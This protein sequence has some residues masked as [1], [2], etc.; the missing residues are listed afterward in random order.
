MEITCGELSEKYIEKEV[1]LNGWCRYIRD[2][3]GKLFIDLADRYGMTQLVFEGTVKEQA[4]KLGKEYVIHAIGVV[5]KREEDT[6][7]RTNPTGSVEV[8]VEKFDIINNSKLPPFE[9]IDEKQSFLPSEELRMKYRYLDLR[10]KEMIKRV[11]FRDK[12]AKVT[13]KYLWDNGFL[14]LETPTLV[15]DTYETGSRTFLVPS[16]F[17]PGK[18]YSLPQSP[19]IYKQL[20]MVAGLDK[21]FQMAKCYRDEDPREDRQPEFTQVDIEVSFKNEKYIQGLIEEL[22]MKVFESLGKKLKIPFRHMAYS[23]AIENY[24]SDK[25]DL[26]FDSRIVDITEIMKL[27]D[28]NI[29]KRVIGGGGRVKAMK[30]EADFDGK[31]GILDKNYMLKVIDTAKSL[32]LGGLTWLYVKDSTIKSEPESIA[33]SIGK[34]PCEKM[35]DAIKAEDGDIIVMCS[36]ASE[37]LLLEV[38]G[39]LRKIIGDKVAKYSSEYEFLWVDEFP[40]FEKDEITGKLKPSHNPF[41]APTPETAHLIETEPEKVLSRQYDIVLN[42]VEIGG[43]SIRINEAELQKRALHAIGMSDKSINDSFGFLIEALEYGAP[44]EGG[45]ALGFDRLIALLYGETDI[46]E[47]ILFPKNKKYESLLDGSPT[48]INPKRLRED[49][50]INFES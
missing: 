39:K 46:R 32:G 40:L 16:R 41:T 21:Y 7:D 18:F 47:F 2:H 43:G 22:M 20:C 19:Q 45:I 42:G 31:K 38:M 15:K 9:L 4:D 27:S 3:G 49:F 28:Y 11:E 33:D 30:F 13:R 48:I 10:R 26:R 17:N 23:Y 1:E 14:E 37:K 36:D 35:K 8:Y 50:K 34:V 6:V 24:G 5:K 25:P 12:I 44:I 29:I